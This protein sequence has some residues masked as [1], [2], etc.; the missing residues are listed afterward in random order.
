MAGLYIHIPFCERRCAY[1]DFYSTVATGAEEEAFLAALKREMTARRHSPLFALHSSLSTVYAGGG[2]P[3]LLSPEA[4]QSLL[5][6]AAGLWDCSSLR[7]VTLEANPEDLTPD[8][9]ARLARTGFNRLSIGI[10]SF[11]DDLLR[12]MNRRHTA[13]R[14][15]EAVEAAG[16]AGFDNI[17]IDLIW[18]IPGMTPAQWERTLDE[19]IA[20]GVQHISAYH[21]TIEPETT[22]GRM[23]LKPVVEAE[24]ER[25]F[26]TLRRKLGEAGFDHYEISNFALPGRRAVHNSAYWSGEAYLGVGP[27]AHSFDGDRRR[28]WVEPDLKKYLEKPS[29][30]GETLT[31]TERHNEMIMTALR[32]AEGLAPI[33]DVPGSPAEDTPRFARHTGALEKLLAEG[34]L[35]RK[36][37]NIAIPPEKFLLSDYIIASLFD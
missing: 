4:L 31:P 32:T 2:T 25:Q 6:H 26:A 7:E 12:L 20:L 5:D 30:G 21:L 3:S 24:S 10:Q 15:R 34:L 35:V 33:R 36:G 29:Y 22:F 37:D 13:R 11:D 28:E 19:A 14:A 23:A 1:C 16:R 18:G 9:L 17:S 27:S 8:Y